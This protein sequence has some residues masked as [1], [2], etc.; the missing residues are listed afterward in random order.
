MGILWVI[1]LVQMLF[2]IVLAVCKMMFSRKFCCGCSRRIIR[3]GGCGVD[4]VRTA[5]VVHGVDTSTVSKNLGVL[6]VLVHFS[7]L[8]FPA[9]FTHLRA[10]LPF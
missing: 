7:A 9:H 3:Y 1:C 10:G 4:E 6:R 2:G 8:W 5:A